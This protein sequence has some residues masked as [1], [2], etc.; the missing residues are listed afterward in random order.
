MPQTNINFS[1][2][3]EILSNIHVVVASTQLNG[4]NFMRVKFTYTVVLYMMH[5]K[6]GMEWGGKKLLC[7]ARKTSFIHNRAHIASCMS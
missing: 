2:E 3:I 1:S 4:G 7:N 6:E 5:V